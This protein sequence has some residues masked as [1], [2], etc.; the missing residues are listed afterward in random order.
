[1]GKVVIINVNMEKLVLLIA[2]KKNKMLQFPKRRRMLHI[3]NKKNRK[4]WIFLAVF[5]G[6]MLKY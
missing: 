6:Q 1:M 5:E 3:S 2:L 4:K